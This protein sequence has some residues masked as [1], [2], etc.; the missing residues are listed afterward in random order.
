MLAAAAGQLQRC[1]AKCGACS[2]TLVRGAHDTSLSKGARPLHQPFRFYIHEDGALDFSDVS[3]ELDS[4]LK[5]RPADMMLPLDIAQHLVDPPLLRAFTRCVSV[6]LS[7]QCACAK[8]TQSSG[9][10]CCPR[11]SSQLSVGAPLLF[12]SA[13]LLFPSLNGNCE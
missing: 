4:L 12:S 3:I 9:F 6:R 7:R 5:G 8:C 1:R 13:R 11:G 10:A 2:D